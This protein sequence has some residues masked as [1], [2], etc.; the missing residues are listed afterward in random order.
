MKTPDEIKKGL[1]GCEDKTNCDWCSLIREC[2]EDDDALAYITQ[3]EQRLAQ[4]E[5]ERDAAVHDLT[6]IAIRYAG[7]KELCEFCG[8]DS[9]LRC[10]FCDSRPEEAFVWKGVCAENTKGDADA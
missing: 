2:E 9:P 10:E 1:R 7:Q 3:L 8:S 4:A 6:L 5:R